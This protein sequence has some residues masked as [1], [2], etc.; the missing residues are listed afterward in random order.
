LLKTSLF[1]LG[2]VLLLFG[3][4]QSAMAMNSN[5]AMTQPILVDTS[6]QKITS[7]HAGQQIGIES[8]LTNNGK[9]EQKFAY[10]VQVLGS[11]SETEYFESTSASML[12]NQSFTTSQIWIPKNTGQYTIEV[13]V[14]NSLSSAIPLTDVSKIPILIN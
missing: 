14:W 11:N 1:L 4:A 5:V 3:F 8:T 12:P 10:M 13:F 9:F 7:F 6:G 2:T